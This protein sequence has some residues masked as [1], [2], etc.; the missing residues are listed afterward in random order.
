MIWSP[1]SWEAAA[2][3]AHFDLD[4]CSGAI[5]RAIHSIAH[6]VEDHAQ[7]A[8]IPKRFAATKL[9]DGDAPMQQLLQLHDSDMDIIEHI[10]R[11]MEKELGT[12]RKQRWRTCA[13]LTSNH[14]SHNV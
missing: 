7:Q 13:T 9:V 4:F 6:I 3:E 5:H 10:I 2:A 14:W 1:R 12:D 11:Q 8:G